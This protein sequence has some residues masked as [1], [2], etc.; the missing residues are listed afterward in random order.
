MLLNAPINPHFKP[1]HASRTTARSV[2][3]LLSVIALG[4]ST[5]AEVSNE[6]L[7]I[8]SEGSRLAGNLWLPDA[9]TNEKIPTILMVHGWGGEK[10]HL[11]GAY[12]PRF[13][14]AGYGVVTFDYR[15]WG[16]S[17][18]KYYRATN[19]EGADEY[20]EVRN[21]VDPIEQ[22]ED[23]R[24]V[25]AF[26]LSD[27]RIDLDRLAIWGTSLGGGLAL[28][29]ASEISSIKVLVTQVGAVN[30]LAN[31]ESDPNFLRRTWNAQNARA[32]GSDEPFPSGGVPGLRGTPDMFKFAQYDPFSLVD[33]LQAATLVIDAAQEELFNNNLNG[34]L[35]Y[36]TIESRLP[37]KR[38][39]TPGGHYAVYSG[40]GF[41]QAVQATLE[42]LDEHL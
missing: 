23:I 30:S 25:Y 39:E 2:L 4:L 13:A 37:A 38:V 11:N 17:E 6:K 28:Q 16:E 31:F 41:A 7:E 15:G 14:E 18:G 40:P 10:S 12:A 27:D 20:R 21:V 9:A 29:I 19:E 42:W 1:T 33:E 24:N 34:K 22:L 8:W 3:A 32:R 35:L 26:L 5:S 36:S